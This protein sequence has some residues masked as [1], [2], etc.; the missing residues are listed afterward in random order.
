[1][2]EEKF[3]V[4]K[5][6]LI[7]LAFFTTGISWSLYNTQ[8][9]QQLDIYFAGFALAGL[10]VGLLMT[11][12]NFLGVIIQPIMG[13]I[14]DNTRS[15]YGRRMPYIIIGVIASAVFF[16]FI[17]TGFGASLVILLIWMFFFSLS[18][19]FYRSQSVALMPDFVRPVHRSKANAII[20]IMGGLGTVAAFTMSLLSDYIGLQFT[21]IIASIIM[22]LAL[23]V[24]FFKVD[25]NDSFSYKLLLEAETVEGERIKEN[26]EKLKLM[27]SIKSI[28]KEEDK[29]TLFMLLTIFF[30][31]LT[32]NGIEGLFSIY[33]GS[34]PNGVLGLSTGLSGFI[35]NAVAIPFILAAF[36]LSLLA[37]KIGRRLCVKIGLVIMFLA[38]LIGFFVPSLTVTIIILIFYGIGY[39]LVNVN[40]IVIVWE[41]AP[42]AK[43]IGTYTG[44]YYFFSVF[45]Q[46][47]GPISVGGLRDLF[48]KTSLLLDGAIFLVLALV[49]IF[50][51]KRGEIELTEEEK[52]TRQKTIS[53]L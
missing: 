10:V 6:F 45:A 47:L 5:T 34:G 35:F 4:K 12:D 8:V 27:E 1:M 53:E 19:G 31:F 42:S 51:V 2:S 18:M 13:S 37:S 7:G 14:S 29:S 25:E 44:L 43:K 49:C 16:A 30:L 20:N 48:G 24:L 40:T 33:A 39:A 46:I 9:N 21:F 26:K 22:I 3:D 23:V 41:L 15:K 50:L 28:F 36:P 38:L 52:L 17:P 32:H 11:L